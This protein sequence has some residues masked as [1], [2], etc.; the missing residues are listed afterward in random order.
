MRISSIIDCLLT[1]CAAL[2]RNK[3]CCRCC[4]YYS[5]QPDVR[6]MCH[7]VSGRVHYM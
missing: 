5:G 6:S 2:W 1:V 7:C 3:E 4:C